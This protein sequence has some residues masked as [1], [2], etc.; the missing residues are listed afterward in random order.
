MFFRYGIR[1]NSFCIF[2]WI[3][4]ILKGVYVMKLFVEKNVRE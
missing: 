1:I 3:K 2:V 4:L